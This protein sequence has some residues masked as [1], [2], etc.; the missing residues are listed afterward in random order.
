M[1][2]DIITYELADG[3]DENH[4][5]KVAGNIIESWMSKQPGF[6]QWDIHKDSI[7]NGYTDIVYW[8]SREDAQNSEQ[9]MVNIPNAGDWF[10]C[11]KEGSISS[12]NLQQ[13]GSFK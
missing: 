3:I 11:Y 4:L 6:I 12:Q 8:E 9:D 10:F 13:I 2:K 7:G 5:L 1:F